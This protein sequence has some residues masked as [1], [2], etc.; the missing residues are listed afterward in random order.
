MPSA[1]SDS[2]KYSLMPQRGHDLLKEYPLV[3]EYG[4]RVVAGMEGDAAFTLN[5]PVESQTD[6]PGLIKP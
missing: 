5:V 1:F 4:G 2:D 6:L 3:E